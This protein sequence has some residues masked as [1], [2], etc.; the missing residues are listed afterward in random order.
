MS[1]TIE[2]NKLVYKIMLCGDGAVGKTTLVNRFI[3]GGF[4]SGYNATIGVDIFSKEFV[5]KNM[6]IKIWD[7]AGQSLFSDFRKK[8]YAGA[9]GGFLVF[10]LTVPNS[11]ENLSSWI[12]EIQEAVSDIPLVLLG[13]KVDIRDLSSITD[14]EIDYFLEQNKNLASYLPTSG[15]TGFNVEKALAKLISLIKIDV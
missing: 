7:I 4:V 15:T 11:F 8:F 9:Q 3:S 12:E 14:D 6:I 10:D 1:V 5:D 13:N 2:N